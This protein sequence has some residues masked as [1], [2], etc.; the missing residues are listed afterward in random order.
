MTTAAGYLRY[1]D[2]ESGTKQ[3][4]PWLLPV[5]YAISP[6]NTFRRFGVDAFFHYLSTHP[7]AALIVAVIILFMTYFVIKKLLKVALILG[8]ILIG[9][10]GYFYYQAPEKFPENMKSTISDVKEQ[11]GKIAEQG[12]NVVDVGK[13]VLD[14][15]KD[16]A[17]TVE[18]RVKRDEDLA[19]K[20]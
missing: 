19:T 11:S 13:E 16:L 4:K 9:V 3:K 14:K 2:I 6:V 1:E 17:E 7:I 5:R 8:L 15:G 10:T 18:K 20:K 12:K